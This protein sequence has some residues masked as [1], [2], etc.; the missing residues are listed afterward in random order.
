MSVGQTE[1]YCCRLSISTS[2][3]LAQHDLYVNYTDK[4]VQF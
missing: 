3:I 2:V 4:L 1:P